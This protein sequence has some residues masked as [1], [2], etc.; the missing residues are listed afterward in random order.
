V[1]IIFQGP[2]VMNTEEEVKQA[3]EDFK[4][5]KNGFEKV[6]SWQS[7]AVKSGEHIG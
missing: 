3:M 6:L 2:F 5:A 1:F 7:E 4:Q